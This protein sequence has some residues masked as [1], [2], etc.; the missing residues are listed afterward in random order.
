MKKGQQKSISLAI[1]YDN[2]PYQDGCKTDWGFSCFI[3][4][5]EK[6]ILFDSGGNG[7][8][9]MENMSKLG[10]DPQD[11]DAV[12]LSHDH[13]DHTGGLATLLEKKGEVDVWVPYFFPEPFKASLRQK[14]ANVNETKNFEKIC[15]GAY[16]TG[17]INGW[18]K[19]QSLVIATSE[20]LALITGCAHPRIVNIVHHA[21][22]LLNQNIQTVFGGFHLAGFE[23]KTIQEIIETLQDEGVAKAGPCH[24]SGEDARRLFAR[25]FGK[26]YLDLGVGRR[27]VIR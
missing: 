7:Q 17:V 15:G 6:T 12:F 10:I 23:D 20:G 3:Q 14:G 2:N 25:A 18:I 22:K 9:L 5:L 26:N 24:C 16:T 13:K 1:V 27:I 11:I 4:G 19:E 21:K 8:I